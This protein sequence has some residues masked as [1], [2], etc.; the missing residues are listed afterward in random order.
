MSTWQT[1]SV[2]QRIMMRGPSYRLLPQ[3]ESLVEQDPAGRAAGGRT[4]VHDERVIGL[5]IESGNR[6]RKSRGV[7]PADSRSGAILVAEA[8]FGFRIVQALESR[9][10]RKRG[11]VDV[12]IA[13]EI[14]TSSRRW[15]YRCRCPSENQ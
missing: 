10:L 1:R 3:C 8:T 5:R 6:I 11:G 14:R 15:P 9:T 7:P 4:A 12:S 2:A 13:E